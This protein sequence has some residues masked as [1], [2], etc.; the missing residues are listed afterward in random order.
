[1][2]TKRNNP[3]NARIISSTRIVYCL[4][5]PLLFCNYSATV[6]YPTNWHDYN[7]LRSESCVQNIVPV[8]IFGFQKLN[9][10]VWFARFYILNKM[11]LCIHGFY[12]CS[13]G[14]AE[15]KKRKTTLHTFKKN[16]IM[17]F[18]Q[19][20]I[21]ILN[22]NLFLFILSKPCIQYIYTSRIQMENKIR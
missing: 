20:G 12:L 1:M 3:Q 8:R 11:I 9:R 4:F 18:Q 16:I 5:T 13:C 17:Y 6:K 21:L 10:Y 7:W 19:S 22:F 15:K 2:V 14:A